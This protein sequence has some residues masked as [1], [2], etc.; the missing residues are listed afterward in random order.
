M[1][2]SPSLVLEKLE[3]VK[4]R[5]AVTVPDR[6]Y[7]DPDRCQTMCNKCKMLVLSPHFPG[8]LKHVLDSSLLRCV[9]I[10][11]KGKC[12]VVS[13]NNPLFESCF[14]RKEQAGHIH[15]QARMKRMCLLV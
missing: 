13:P 12:F 10:I 8:T 7:F 1:S 11:S 5:S 4:S 15:M 14:W 6:S 2:F 3:P 9:Q